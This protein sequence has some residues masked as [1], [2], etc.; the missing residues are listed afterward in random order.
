MH[1]L[2]LPLLLIAVWVEAGEAISIVGSN[3]GSGQGLYFELRRNGKAI[4][5][6]AWM[7][8]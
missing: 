2:V 7:A 6:A 1:L 5:P 4:D 3:P 8:R